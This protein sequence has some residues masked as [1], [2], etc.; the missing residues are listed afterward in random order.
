MLA[1][2]QKMNNGI[3]FNLMVT[4]RKWQFFCIMNSDKSG[5]N[6]ENVSK[7][8]LDIR[9]SKTVDASVMHKNKTTNS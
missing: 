3:I 2:L 1:V 4:Q 9:G 6:Y 5:I 8:A 7:R